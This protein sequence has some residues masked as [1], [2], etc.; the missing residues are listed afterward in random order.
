MEKLTKR[1]IAREEVFKLLFERE[2][3]TK[4]TADELY[5]DA[6]AARE[7]AED[8]YILPTLTGVLQNLDTIYA[9]IDKH[10]VGWKRNRLS[11]VTLA[12]MELCIY[13]MRFCKD[14]PLRVSL[15]E[16]IELS[17]RYAEEKARAFLNGVLNAVMKEAAET[18]DDEA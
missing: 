1:Q 2:F 5:A 12:I 13:E 10:A 17:K 16:A 3:N 8:P 6:L 7:F 14:I 18:R 11:P 9:D 4:K 15:N